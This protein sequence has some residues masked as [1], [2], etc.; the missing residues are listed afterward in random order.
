MEKAEHQLKNRETTIEESRP[1]TDGIGRSTT[2]VVG[3]AT[4]VERAKQ[5][6]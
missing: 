4:T 6:Q 3:R 2:L 5:Q 1:L